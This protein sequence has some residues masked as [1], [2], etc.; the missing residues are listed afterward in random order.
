MPVLQRLALTCAIAAC[1]AAPAFAQDSTQSPTVA[2]TTD[3]ALAAA[4]PD[5]EATAA[6]TREPA[7]E[8]HVWPTDNYLGFNSGLLS[9]FGALG[10]VADMEAHKG[11][12]ATVKELMADYLGPRVQLEELEKVGILKTLNISD[13]RIII[14]EPT[15]SN[16]D[17]KAN[18]ELKAATKAL[19]AKIKAGQRITDSKAT[20]YG[21][22][23][24]TYVMYHKA[25]M[26]GSNLFVGTLYRD[27]SGPGGAIRQSAG[28]V[29]NPLENFPPKT[30]DM[31]E[32]AKAELRDAFA[33]DFTEWAQKK[34]MK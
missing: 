19:N 14:E 18:P 13:Y 25:M 24:I 4:V 20:C 33:K 15:P 28:A 2:A 22:L 31:V 32:P 8:L 23:L 21:E 29:K 12:V 30:P 10:A 11:R 34:L 5:A 3:T 9:G 17:V 26:Y 27:F 16:E 6:P 1:T 7:C